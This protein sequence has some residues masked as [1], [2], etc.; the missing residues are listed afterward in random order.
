M[1]AWDK[2][3]GGSVGHKLR[4][5][6]NLGGERDTERKKERESEVPQDPQKT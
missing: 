4:Q 3:K 2:E 1:H 5:K 6:G